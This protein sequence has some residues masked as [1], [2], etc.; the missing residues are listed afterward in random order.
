MRSQRCGYCTGSG[1]VPRKYK[2][3]NNHGM[4]E[5]ALVQE[6]CPMCKGHGFVD[7]QKVKRV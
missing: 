1:K 4:D 5:Y 3:K 2:I 7:L 6:I